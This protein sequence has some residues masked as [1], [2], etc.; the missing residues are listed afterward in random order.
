MTV[1]MLT[2]ALFWAIRNRVRSKTERR[3]QRCDP[4]FGATHFHHHAAN[5]P[6]A[7]GMTAT[8][9]IGPVLF[10]KKGRRGAGFQPF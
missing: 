8:A 3:G 6:W 4:T 9:L 1:G 7:N 5:P 2:N 10:L